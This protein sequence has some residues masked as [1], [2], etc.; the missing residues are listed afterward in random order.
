MH[1]VHRGKSLLLEKMNLLSLT[2]PFLEIR[3]APL[4]YEQS[5][6]VKTPY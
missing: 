1:R 6:K 5:T 2:S 3:P 4:D